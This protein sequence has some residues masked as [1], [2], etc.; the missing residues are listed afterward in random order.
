MKLFFNKKK[1][2]CLGRKKKMVN[3]KYPIDTGTSK[4]RKKKKKLKKKKKTPK[5]LLLRNKYG[6][7]SSNNPSSN[8]SICMYV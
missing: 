3:I 4:N 7:P 1:F 6:S 8:L 2:C 5:Y